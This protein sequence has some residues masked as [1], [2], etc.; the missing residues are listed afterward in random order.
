MARDV[1]EDLAEFASGVADLPVQAQASALNDLIDTLACAAAG[2]GSG[3]VGE[4]RGIVSD[5]S[6][7]PEA[8]LW[9][10]AEA[11]PAPWAAL[12]NGLVSHAV[13]FDDTHDDAILHAGITVIP[14]V[15]AAA[16][17][18]GNVAGSELIAGIAVGVD[19]ACRLALATN[20]GPGET[21]WLLTPLCGTFGAAA[22][23]ARTLGL[24][25]E[26]TLNA[27]GLAYAQAAGN[28]QATIDGAL[29]KRLQAGLAAKAGTL[30][31]IMAAAGITGAR[32]V[33][34]G[35]RGFYAV[36]QAGDYDRSKITDGL[37]EQF[38]IKKL[39]F[40]PHPCCRWTHAA[41]E[42]AL[43]ARAENVPPASLESIHVS[44][45]RQAYNS[46]GDPIAVKR[47]P[48]NV[49]D[50]QFSIP[51]AVAAALVDGQV[52]LEHFT[53]A[54]IARADLLEVAAKVSV[55]IGDDW[56]CNQTRS[57]S[58]ARLTL[59]TADGREITRTV[60]RPSGGPGDPNIDRILR[61]K[62]VRCCGITGLRE[63]LAAARL[64]A[65]TAIGSADNA[66]TVLRN[67]TGAV[68]PA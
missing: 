46:T 64:E 61:D 52:G 24:D 65:L 39:S 67:V 1:A 6:G 59:L 56:S 2:L 41:L 68:A 30:A 19:V 8:R 13:E 15:A 42:A 23:A 14:A 5:W 37:G 11:A 45:N 55:D 49:V 29:A 22:G 12:Y 9:F 25:A 21:G 10:G 4:I 44:V 48:R 20:R 47:K 62:F 63:E 36:Y 50:A 54:A 58:P 40:K 38:E 18:R 51:F 57:V 35:K 32:Q 7:K 34:D 17:R 3:G 26:Q 43:A 53:E 60:D 28:G 66:V 33:F 16:E 27:L 31:A